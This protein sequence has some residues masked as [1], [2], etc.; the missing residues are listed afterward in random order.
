[1]ARNIAWKGDGIPE[2]RQ[3]VKNAIYAVTKFT[4]D[5]GLRTYLGAWM[6]Q[7]YKGGDLS[8]DEVINVAHYFVTNLHS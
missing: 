6:L 7:D 8:E 4:K 3:N 2:G 5:S 1:M